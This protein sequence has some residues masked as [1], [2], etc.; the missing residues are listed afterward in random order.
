MGDGGPGA[1]GPAEVP[2]ALEDDPNKGDI[3]NKGGR[4]R[5]CKRHPNVTQPDAQAGATSGNGQVW[6]TSVDSLIRVAV[7]DDQNQPAHHYPGAAMMIMQPPNLGQFMYQMPATQY[8]PPEYLHHRQA[9]TPSATPMVPY[10]AQPAY[11]PAPVPVSTGDPSNRCEPHAS[12]AQAVVIPG[13]M[14]PS[15]AVAPLQWAGPPPVQFEWHECSTCLVGADSS[16]RPID[17]ASMPAWGRSGLRVSVCF[18][19]DL[20]F[21]RDRHQWMWHKKWALPTMTVRIE[22]DGSEP[23]DSVLPTPLCVLVSA[24]T[25][26]EE[27]TE[28][29]DQGLGGQCQQ[30]VDLGATAKSKAVVS[31]SRLTFQW[32]SFNCGG[33]PFH[34]VVTV[35]AD[36]KTHTAPPNPPETPPEIPRATPRA[37]SP[38]ALPPTPPLEPTLAPLAAP[39]SAPLAAPPPSQ[40]ALWPLVSI[41]S[42]PV[43]VDA[44]KR[45]K[46]ERPH[47]QE[48]DI[49]F[50]HRQRGGHV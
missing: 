46:S 25:V 8:P 6:E 29:L 33:R 4:G 32:T 19:A 14:P 31:F 21:W 2:K 7:W 27:H 50:I 42:L 38:P 26:R 23:A 36:P 22:R 15:H 43:H 48:D 45:S 40:Q 5:G 11:Q 28:L 34:L 12:Y 41:R 3:P 35:L 47:A 17:R 13:C 16:G 44:R 49:R 18:S 37:T 39:P 30:W 20:L 9:W 10:Y 24:G 1:L